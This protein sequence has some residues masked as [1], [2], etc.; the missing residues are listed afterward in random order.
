MSSCAEA[1]APV[2]PPAVTE[3]TLIFLACNEYGN[4]NMRAIAAEF[5]HLNRF[6][7]FVYVCEHGGWFLGFRRDLSIWTTANDVA[8]LTDP[9][10]QPTGWNGRSIRREP[11]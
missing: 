4:E 3:Y 10:P 2:A 6:Q 9:Q 1:V 8:I 5:F 11:Q 7:Q